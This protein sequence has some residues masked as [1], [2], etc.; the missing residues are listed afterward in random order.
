MT[1]TIWSFSIDI[2]F[3][4]HQ[5]LYSPL[6][7]LGLILSS[8]ILFYADGSTVLKATTYTQD[9][10][11]TEQ[12]QA[13]ISTPLDPSVLASEDSSCLR[14][15]GHCDRLFYRFFSLWLYS[16]ILGLGPSMKLSI[17]FQLLDL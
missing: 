15:R 5:W 10:T 1:H 17:L 9:N 8:V 4:S 3:F 6:L 14:P 11:N 12:T 7:G 2:N 16:P 13:Q